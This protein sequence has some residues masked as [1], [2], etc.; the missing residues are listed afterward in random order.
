MDAG[1]IKS[2]LLYRLSYGLEIL[3]PQGLLRQF[4]H[5]SKCQ[6]E[7]RTYTYGKQRVPSITPSLNSHRSSIRRAPH[8]LD[9]RLAGSLGQRLPALFIRPVAQ[10][11]FALVFIKHAVDIIISLFRRGFWRSRRRDHRPTQCYSRTPNPFL[12]IEEQ[13]AG[14]LQRALQLDACGVLHPAAILGP[15]DGSLVHSGSRGQLADVPA[16]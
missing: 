5:P 4:W 15:D 8:D 6:N 10:H 13:D 11:P 16:Q 1:K 14:A 7:T 9:E 3:M 2:Q 12:A